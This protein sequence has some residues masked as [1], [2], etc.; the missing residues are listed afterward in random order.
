MHLGHYPPSFASL[1]KRQPPDTIVRGLSFYPIQRPLYRP[2]RL[3]LHQGAFEDTGK[4]LRV[5]IMLN[6]SSLDD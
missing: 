2:L 1:Y 3:F 4:L 6:L 5:D